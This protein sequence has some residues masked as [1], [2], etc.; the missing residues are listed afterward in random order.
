MWI[1]LLNFNNG[2][3]LRAG[4]GSLVLPLHQDKFGFQRPALGPAWPATGDF[5]L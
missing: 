2:I 1:K 5:S 3:H 4:A